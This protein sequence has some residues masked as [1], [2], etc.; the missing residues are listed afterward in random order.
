VTSLSVALRGIRYRP[1]RSL[2]VLLL[3]AV[4]TA[5]TVIAPAYSRAAQQSVLT[6]RLASAPT[7]A[8]TLL[9]R[10]DPAEAGAPVLESTTEAKLE[11]RLLLSRRTALT[12]HL[13]VPVG[14]ADVSTLASA[15]G[16]GEPV[17]ARLSYRDRVCDHVTVVAGQC[18]GEAGTVML[19]ERS[20]RDH[21]VTVGQRIGF[22]GVRQEREEPREFT[23]VGVYEP[24]D[25]SEPYWGVGSYFA[26]SPAAG[27]A[28]ATMDAVF[29][30]D[31]EDVTL[32]GAPPTV[33]LS[34]PV[35]TE[36]LRLDDVEALRA[37]LAG[38]TTDVN[39]AELRLITSLPGVLSD[40]DAEVSSLGRTVPVVAV[41]LVL[42]CWFILILLVAAL[43]DERS[44]EVALAKLR[45][46]SPGRAARFGRA[47][48][49]ILVLVAA[50]VGGLIGLV[51]VEAAARTLLGPRVHVELRWP[52]AIAAGVAVAAGLLAVRLGSG[53]ILG[54][55]VLALLRRVPER[56][57]WR[58]GLAEAGVLALA[59]ASLVAALSDQTAPLAMLAPALLAVVAGILTARLLG[60]WS[61]LRVRRH[62]RRGKVPALLAHAQLSRRPL[63]QRI[64]LVVTVAVA[65]LSFAATAWDV[66]AQARRDVA[67]DTIGADRVIEV[68][69]A[70]PD[71][72]VAA[73]EATAP[74]AAMPVVR[75]TEPY[76]GA[77]VELV[78]VR[79][80]RFADVAV[81][82]GRDRDEL[83]DL[84]ARLRPAGAPPLAVDSFVEVTASVGG[85]SGRPRLAALVAPAGEPAR[86]V[87][88]GGLADGSRRYRASLSSCPAGCRLLGLAVTR[89]GSGSQPMA[90]VVSVERID[91]GAGPLT[92]GFEADG[93]WRARGSGAP[94]QVQAGP[95]LRIEVNASG[96]GDAVVEYVDTPTALPVA[97]AG[98][99]PADDATATEFD[100]PGFG[101]TPQHF[102]V[103]GR[104]SALPRVGTRAVLFDLDYAVRSAQR[105]STLSDNTRLRYEVW[106]TA[107]APADLVSRLAGRGLEIY[108]E[109][110]I[111]AERAR[112][113]RGAPALGLALYL[114]AGVAALA[115]AIGAVLL[116]AYIGAQ[117]RRYELAALRV[118]GVR[119]WSLRRG[120]LR[121]Y[122][123]L[124][125]LPVLVGAVT[126]VA[127]AALMLPG[128]PLV[129]VGTSLGEV[130]Y[131]PGLGALPI[132]LAA[133]LAGL[134]LAVLAVQRLVGA[135]TPDRLREGEAA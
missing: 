74:D 25:V 32:P 30:A 109:E 28:P 131:E 29:V 68:G 8:T 129:T 95:A 87:D 101:E 75:V 69:A 111:V 115:L 67:T 19:S 14:G 57:R 36:G 50:P 52:V 23:V 65:M 39:A 2:I 5:A 51:A 110:S 55:P 9:V 17:A 94:A 82:R 122:G 12:E 102:A 27:D 7:G 90:A 45:G 22:R 37:D 59:A 16:G 47:E 84:A 114:I 15:E 58:A 123:H 117:T 42:V 107:D 49:L 130:T 77:T 64:M 108:G 43:T 121:E 92:A 11:L 31:E 34:Y 120:L 18:A 104:E 63:G 44:P 93:R 134:V 132:A 33:H 70:H 106:A 53:R 89:T 26:A 125:G 103:V 4:A 99:T 10:S 116:T 35:G 127:G 6:D 118:A 113:A 13:Q 73:V 97:L 88:L 83:A 112:L 41:P 126:G 48:T 86:P 76:A 96:P 1:G 20:A 81:W 119:S 66:A 78:G 40:V 79:S 62:A 46:Y 133:T 61:R 60:L 71:A 85:L 124:L 38:L 56:S 98:P 105:S 72:L 21:N 54:Q 100:F 135:A 128:I 80:D 3:A 91:T 24:K